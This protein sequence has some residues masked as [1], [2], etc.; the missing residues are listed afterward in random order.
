MTHTNPSHPLLTP[1]RI[2]KF[3]ARLNQLSASATT[4]AEAAKAFM[5]AT[6]E[7]CASIAV[8]GLVKLA[9]DHIARTVLKRERRRRRW[10]RA[11][12]GG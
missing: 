4:M 8:E 5:R 7:L 1:E 6:T 11:R 9:A 10:K 12:A 3:G 2:A